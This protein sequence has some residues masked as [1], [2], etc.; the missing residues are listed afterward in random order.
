LSWEVF[1]E[2]YRQEQQQQ[3]TCAP[4]AY[5]RGTGEPSGLPERLATSPVAFLAGLE[6]RFGAACCVC[7]E[8]LTKPGSHC[9]RI[10]LVQLVSAYQ[11]E[12]I[13]PSQ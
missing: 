10:E 4:I 1:V 3:T 2:R 7:H 12:H 8:D 11:Q 9:H 13:N 6:R 5:H